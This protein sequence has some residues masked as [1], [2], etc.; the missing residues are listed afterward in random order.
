MKQYFQLC[1]DRIIWN[2]TAEDYGHRDSY[3]FSGFGIDCIIGYGVQDGGEVYL[4]RYNA[5]P[6]LRIQPNE[7][8]GTFAVEYDNS[9]LPSLYINGTRE[10]EY[11]ERFE[12]DGILHASTKTASGVCI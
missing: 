3:E 8:H 7:T 11:A 4:S 9:R 1:G 12:I 6:K 10:T 2:V 5:F